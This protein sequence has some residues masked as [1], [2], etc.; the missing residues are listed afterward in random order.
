M[1][2][3]CF[4]QLAGAAFDLTD[5]SFLGDVTRSP[6]VWIAFVFVSDESDTRA[7]GVYVDDIVLSAYMVARP[8]TTLT[9]CPDGSCDYTSIQ[10]AI[11]EAIYGDIICG[12]RDL[13][14][15]NRYGEWGENQGVW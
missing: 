8:P 6:S 15:I 5:V 13:Q 3:C 9:V 14:R 10:D 11:D 7:E 12:S 2:R 4:R 1:V